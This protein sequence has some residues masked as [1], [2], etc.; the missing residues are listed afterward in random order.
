MAR[1][2]L[3]D[4]TISLK[5]GLSGVATI[6]DASITANDTTIS[7]SAANSSGVL[8]TNDGVVT[9]TATEAGVAW[10]GKS[11]VFALDANTPEGT[12]TAAYANDTLTITVNSGANTTTANIVTAVNTTSNWTAVETN[13]GNFE[14][15]VDDSVNATTSNGV[16]AISAN[17]TVTLGDAGE[18]TI[19]AA[20]TGTTWNGKTVAFVLSTSTTANAPTAVYASNTITI[21]VNSTVN[22]PT[23]NIVSVVTALT[24]WNATEDTPGEFSPGDAG[25]VVVT[26]GGYPLIARNGYELEAK[27]E[28]KIEVDMLSKIYVIA[29]N[30]SQYLS[31]RTIGN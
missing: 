22:T 5:D 23:A 21:T 13:A 10:N 31:W 27:E 6:N 3:R 24:N 14:P 30:S 16:N 28:L 29:S 1:V 4:C 17:T 19:T 25:I 7:I 15:S 20:A 8:T 11:I 12:P 9:I 2:D 18:F 26:S